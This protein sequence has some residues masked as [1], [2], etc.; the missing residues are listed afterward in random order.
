MA[1]LA[2]AFL[3]SAELARRVG[4]TPDWIRD[5]ARAG[6]IPFVQA[7]GL[8]LFRPEIVEHVIRERAARRRRVKAKATSA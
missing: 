7:S 2:Y 4:V 6:R 1:E 3:T 5:L 8:R